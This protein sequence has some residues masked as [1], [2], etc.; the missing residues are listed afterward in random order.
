MKG[1]KHNST[2]GVSSFKTFINPSRRSET[3]AANAKIHLRPETTGTPTLLVALGL[4]VSTWCSVP[5]S[6]RCRWERST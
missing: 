1:D 4:G 6:G 3:M 2:A 5:G